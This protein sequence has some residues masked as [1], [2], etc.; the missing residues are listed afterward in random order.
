MNPVNRISISFVGDVSFT[1][2]FSKINFD[3]HTI[4][5]SDIK[6]LFLSNDFNV[7]NLEG[8]VGSTDFINPDKTNISGN[9]KTIELL[10]EHNIK[11]FNLSNNHIFDCGKSG[12]NATIDLID[13]NKCQFFGAG[14]NLTKASEILYISKNGITVSLIGISDKN[15]NCA[16]SNN[17]GVFCAENTKLLKS[18]IIEA[19]KNSDY[20]IL[21]YHGGEEYTYYPSPKKYKFLRKLSKIKEV[22]LIICHHSHT[23]Q[24]I[25]KTDKKLIFYSLGNFIF[26]IPSHKLYNNTEKSCILNLQFYKN[27]IDFRLIPIFINSEK[28]KIEIGDKSNLEFINEISNFENYGHKWKKDAY[29]VVYERNKIVESKISSSEKL[30]RNSKFYKIVFSAKFYN[31]VFKLLTRTID[32]QIFISAFMY[33]LFNKK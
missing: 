17:P 28:C 4:F 10:S 25:E 1:G 29:R 2:V 9:I 13:K 20:V 32:R 12:L 15:N 14:E 26:D 19:K 30:L 27:E 18:K 6:N 23:F 33:K 11:V 31:K 8:P 24:G 22:D 21:N 5:S 16:T 7:C 3:N